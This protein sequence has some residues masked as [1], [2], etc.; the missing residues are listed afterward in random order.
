MSNIKILKFSMIRCGPCAALK[1]IID[2]VKQETG[3]EVVSYD[4]D[5]HEKIF[6]QYG[7]RAAP[8]LIFLKNNLE[9]GRKIGMMTKE[10]LLKT[11]E[12]LK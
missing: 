8:T 6:D 4:A 1:P 7:I 11:I 3:I 9:V 12:E 5:A 10:T 2:Q